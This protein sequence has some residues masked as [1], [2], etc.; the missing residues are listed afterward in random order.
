MPMKNYFKPDEFKCRCGCNDNIMDDIFMIKINLARHTS[1]IPYIINS[2]KRCI[3]HNKEVGGTSDS[4]HLK[5][6]AADIKAED[7]T[8]RFKIMIGLLHSGF[9]RIGIAK[10]FIHA[11]CDQTKGFN[12]MWVY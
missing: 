8:T 9:S 1:N 4:S 10:T 5:G 3:K 2:G 11:D 7:S 12:V 6:I